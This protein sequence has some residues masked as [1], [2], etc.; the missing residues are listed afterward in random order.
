[1]AGVLLSAG[2]IAAEGDFHSVALARQ[3]DLRLSSYMTAHSVVG[4][5]NNDPD[6]A[7]CLAVLRGMGITKV[8][9]EVYR[10]GLVVEQAQLERVRDFLRGHG[11]EVVG[12][13]ATVPGGDFGVRQKG[14]LGWFNWQNPKTQ[15]DLKRV[16]RMAAAV[17]DEFIVDDFLCTGDVSDESK[18]AKGDQAWSEYRR[19]LL[20]RLSTEV[21]ITPARE[22]NPD[23]TM[24]IKYPQWYDRFHLFGYDVAREPALF[25]RV[26][27]GTETRGAWTQR[28]GFVQP[29]EGFINYRWIAGLS[30]GKIGGAWFDHGDCDGLDFLEQAY[31]TVLAGA[32]EIVFF[33][34]G[35]LAQGHDGHALIR[36][37]FEVLADLAKAVRAHPVT[38]VAA[39]K[40]PH[41]DAGGDLYV[42]D[43][44]GM[45]GV[46][47]VPTA[48]FPANAPVVFL[49]TQAA[50]D[51]DIHKRVADLVKRKA[52]IVMTSGFIA[53]AEKSRTFA[54]VA[55][56]DWPYDVAPTRAPDVYCGEEKV[57]V[58]FGLDLEA[59][60]KPA[61]AEVLLMA[62]VGEQDVPF[63]TRHSYDGAEVFVL[64]TH[65]YSQA[66]FSAVGEV[67]LSPRRLGLLEVPR[68]W[69]NAIRDAFNA[70]LG[71]PLDAPTRVTLQPLGDTGWVLYNYNLEAVNIALNGEAMNLPARSMRWVKGK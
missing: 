14:P 52:R 62:R 21:F 5:F 6:G 4:L 11:F 16:V 28:F 49:P 30:Q 65:T 34:Y 33:N 13:I 55:G 70:P 15:N 26:W 60:I 36:R 12:G 46:P 41:S 22:V 40:P 27:V 67:L 17:F 37:D 2:V 44:V 45:L 18:A 57:A 69:A 58:E 50:A 59:A 43:F 9:L 7:Q 48:V 31:Q 66:D 63:L 3:D 10:G 8:C 32:P 29:Y 19:D 38:G 39:Y 1:M 23:I 25:D 54:G 20:V 24:V 47:L 71:L 35:N 64:N 51:P 68:S 56:L 61:G 53:A 42:M